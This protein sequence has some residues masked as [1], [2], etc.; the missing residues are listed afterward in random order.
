[1][2]VVLIFWFLMLGVGI[3]SSDKKGKGSGDCWRLATIDGQA[4][5]PQ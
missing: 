3:V 4:E 2:P 5:R 1:M